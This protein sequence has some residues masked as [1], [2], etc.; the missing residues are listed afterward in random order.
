MTK[1]NLSKLRSAWEKAKVAHL[2]ID[3]QKFMFPDD[4]DLDNLRENHIRGE[5]ADKTLKLFR[6]RNRQNMV[7]LSERTSNADDGALVGITPD[8]KRDLEFQKDGFSAFKDPD[9]LEE[10][11]AN[12]TE[13]LIITGLSYDMCV[14]ETIKDAVEKGFDVYVLKE[15]VDTP[16]DEGWKIKND[17]PENVSL[18]SYQDLE[19]LAQSKSEGCKFLPLP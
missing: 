10:L 6:S 7:I 12:K 1:K 18:I 11:Q 4:D 13:T 5:F 15:G 2:C 8:F 17:Y 19:R 16:N 3:F 9:L 14:G